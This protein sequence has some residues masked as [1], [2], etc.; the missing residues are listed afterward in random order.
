M[1]RS[2]VGIEEVAGTECSFYCR[3]SLPA[4]SFSNFSRSV[5]AFDQSGKEYAQMLTAVT[6]KY[7][8]MRAYY[9]ALLPTRVLFGGKDCCKEQ[10]VRYQFIRRDD[11]SYDYSR[12]LVGTEMIAQVRGPADVKTDAILE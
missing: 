7:C 9:D 10:R 12:I 5:H 6:H 11:L 3:N 1:E 2:D 8:M 4:H